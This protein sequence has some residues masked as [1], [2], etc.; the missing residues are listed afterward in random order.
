MCLDA[1]YWVNPYADFEGEKQQH[2]A[3]QRNPYLF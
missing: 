1:R 2:L 3:A